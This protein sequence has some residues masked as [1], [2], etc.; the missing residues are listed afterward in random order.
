MFKEYNKKKSSALIW[1]MICL[2]MEDQLS[3][4]ES[5]TTKKNLGT[6]SVL[7]P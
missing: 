2:Y 7:D 1:C 6:T 3:N 4:H 5:R